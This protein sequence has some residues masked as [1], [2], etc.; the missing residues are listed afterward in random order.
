MQECDFTQKV[1]HP[2]VYYAIISLTVYTCVQEAEKHI[3]WEK[4]G[5]LLQNNS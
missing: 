5:A 3:L 4:W 2:F 1:L